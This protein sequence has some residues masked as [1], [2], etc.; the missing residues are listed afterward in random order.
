LSKNKEANKA[1]RKARQT[2]IGFENIIKEYVP[3]I[4]QHK[5]LAKIK[6]LIE[7]KIDEINA[8]DHIETIRNLYPHLELDLAELID[9]VKSELKQKLIGGKG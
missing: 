7:K 3:F 5:A 9:D 6:S 8:D 1:E 4:E 2:M